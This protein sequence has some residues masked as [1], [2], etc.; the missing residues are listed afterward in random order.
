MQYKRF[1]DLEIWKK[2]VEI[3]VIIY[4]LANTGKLKNDFAT[5]DHL[6]KTSLSISNNI[7][8][9]FEYNNNNQFIKYL[10]IAKSSAGELRNQVYVLKEAEII[11]KEI[12]EN[13]YNRCLD[14]SKQIS[15]FIKYLK[16]YQK[17]KKLVN[18]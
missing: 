12:Y 16:T 7:A 3:A 17:N 4:K 1:E 10:Y 14:V 13:I 11:D 15:N 6:R 9:G 8:E 2:A 18:L 5:N